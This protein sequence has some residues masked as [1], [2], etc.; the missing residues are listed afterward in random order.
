MKDKVKNNIKHYRKSMTMYI[1]SNKLFISYIVLSLIATILVRAFTI[2]NIFNLKPLLV[3]LAFILIIGS[4]GYFIKSNKQYKYYMIWL[5]IYTLAGFINQVYYIFYNSFASFGELAGLGQAE[6]VTGSI[7]E[8]IKIIDFIYILIPL[9]FY[10]IH[11]KLSNKSYYTIIS[12]IEKSKK[13]FVTTLL[14]GIILLAYSLSTATGT[15]YSRLV[16]QWNRSYIVERFGIIMYQGNDLIQTLRPKISS[17]FGYEESAKLFKE[18]FTSD[19]NKYDSTN[20]Y[21]NILDGY[22]V[23]FVHME[24]ME[25]FLMDLEFNGEEVTPTINKLASEGMFF[26]NFY[27]QVSSGT[28]SDSEFTLLTSLLP[29]SSGIVFTSYY[30]RNYITIPKLLANKGYYTFSMHGNYASM[31]NREKVHPNLGYQEMYFRES[32]EIPDKDSA[33]YIN[34][35]ISDSAFFKQVIPKLENIEKNNTNYMGTIITLSNHSPFTFLDKYGEFDLST[36]I[37]NEDGTTSSVDYLSDTAVGKYIKSAHYADKSLGEFIDYINNSDYFNNTVFVFYGDHDAKLSRSEVNTLYNMNYATGELYTEEDSEYYDYN[38]YEHD[39]NKNTPLIIWTKNKTIRSK[40]SGTVSYVMGMYD[41]MP[42]I[43]NMLGIK[44][45]Y[46]IGHDIFNIKNNN[47]VIF[48]NGNFLTN[49]LYYVNS[50][51][52]YYVTKQGTIID[53]D[54]IE[55]CIE[56]VEKRLE[57]SNA[58]IVHDLI[59]NE[60]PTLYSEEINGSKKEQ[61]NE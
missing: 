42:T 56:Y 29:V 12:K 27:P 58:I 36:T 8:K 19:E 37:T 31:W 28:S 51:E 9:T 15:D 59:Y 23:V 1:F 32:F 54:Y 22:N 45:E 24:S 60:G 48:P 50:D 11:K 20:K 10:F 17:L 61:E 47:I 41:V 4:L 2:N 33:D 25:S 7:F 5:V 40:L 34:L 35:G 38:S 55:E 53:E 39:L 6:T 57:V 52:K 49:S 21:T 3:D 18:F 30:D 16:K 13:M 43:G 14:V 44:N 46:A 26:E